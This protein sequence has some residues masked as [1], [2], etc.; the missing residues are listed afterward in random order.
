MVLDNIEINM[1]DKEGGKL[2]SQ[3]VK[4]YNVVKQLNCP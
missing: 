2:G 4:I 3:P 1:F